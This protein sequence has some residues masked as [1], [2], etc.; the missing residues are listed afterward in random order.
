MASRLPASCILWPAGSRPWC[1]ASQV[2]GNSERIQQQHY[3]ALLH[4]T[5][6]QAASSSTPCAA[7]PCWPPWAT[8]SSWWWPPCSGEMPPWTVTTCTRQ[9]IMCIQVASCNIEVNV[10][11]HCSLEFTFAVA[12][13]DP[14]PVYLRF[15]D[16]GRIWQGM[17]KTRF[18]G[19]HYR[20]LLYYCPQ[21]LAYQF[22]WKVP[23]HH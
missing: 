15:W 14:S 23:R 16:V 12:P 20:F 2:R 21:D 18:H 7:S 9:A 3:D 6:L 1:R 19:F 17:R 11:Q 13:F 4:T 5:I 10:V 22:R 8:P